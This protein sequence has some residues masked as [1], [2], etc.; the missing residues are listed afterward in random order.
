MDNHL[1]YLRGKMPEEWSRVNTLRQR[2]Q[3]HIDKL[4]K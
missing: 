4:L 2:L 1:L 3:A